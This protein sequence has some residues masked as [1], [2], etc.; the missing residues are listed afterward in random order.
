MLVS[1]AV[2]WAVFQLPKVIVN[3]KENSLTSDSTQSQSPVAADA[4]HPPTPE[5]TRNAINILRSRY[6][7]STEEEKNAI[8]ADSLATLYSQAGKFD[9]AGYFA[10]EA[11]SF[12]KTAESWAEAGNAYYQAYTF[13]L[14]ESRQ[15][16]WAQKARDY[17][18]KVLAAEP[19]NLEV[20][21]RMAMTY[22][23]SS[24]P[25]QGIQLLREVLAEDPN[26]REALFNMGML[27]VQSGQYARAVERLEKLTTLYPDHVQGH[28]LLGIALM[29]T[30]EKKRAKQQFEKVK[31]MDTDPSVQ[32]TADSYL[33]DL[34]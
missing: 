29:N 6:L 15:E 18:T 30:G 21:T 5:S 7:S 2:I 33:Q 11:A 32:A 25:M 9:S 24:N 3:N 31:Q 1:V 13:A 14:D 22:L 26:N 34:K 12:F 10:E 23:S 19:G 16:V 17:Y 4:M 28:L 8:F 20:K 27:S